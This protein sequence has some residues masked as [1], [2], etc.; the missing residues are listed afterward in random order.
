MSTIKV[1]D[2]QH[3][4]SSNDAI[5]LASDSSVALKFSGSSKLTTSSTG[6]SVTGTCTATE[7]SGSAA[8]LTA[9][10][11][12]NLTGTLP[13]LSAAN[14]TSI[15]AA[16]LT[17]T[18]PAIDGSNLTGISTSHPAWFGRQDTAHSAI[19]NSWTTIKNLG[20]AAVNPSV[21]SSGWDESNGIFTVQSGQAGIYYAFGGAAIDD[22]QSDDYVLCGISKNGDNPDVYGETR[23]QSSES[24]G[25]YQAQISQ[26]FTLAV[27][28][29]LRCKVLHNE[30]SQE[31]TEQYYTY[32]G[33]FRIFAT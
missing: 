31:Q 3:T 6:V 27:G 16:N 18:L 21:N 7:F 13:A 15:P 30:G 1:Q 19:N 23:A 4:A 25:I 33:G 11:A 12:A 24:N 8:S 5:S 10:P 14:L 26:V 9:L 2:I 32:F 28:D 17:G 20:T 22:I 29:T